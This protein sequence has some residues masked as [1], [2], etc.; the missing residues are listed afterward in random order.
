[1]DNKE[2]LISN[3]SHNIKSPITTAYSCFSILIDSDS[4]SNDDKYLIQLGLE[5]LDRGLNYYKRLINEIENLNEEILEN[6]SKIPK[7]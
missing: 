7:K 4:I 1:M 3:I 5:S 2:E 6:L